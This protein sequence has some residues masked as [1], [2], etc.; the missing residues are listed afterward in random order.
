MNRIQ[1]F[2]VPET[3]SSAVAVVQALRDHAQHR[4]LS[5]SDIVIQALTMYHQEVLC[6]PKTS[7][8]NCSVS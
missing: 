5:F 6:P 8:Q 4:R 7:K 3:N 1:T 2:S